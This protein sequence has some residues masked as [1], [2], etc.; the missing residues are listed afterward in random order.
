MR[1]AIGK[2]LLVHTSV[3]VSDPQ[4]I[5]PSDLHH[6]ER[7][8]RALLIGAAGQELLFRM[9]GQPHRFNTRVPLL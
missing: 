2:G 4:M 7:L 9:L 3:T 5:V 6:T 1:K 8:S